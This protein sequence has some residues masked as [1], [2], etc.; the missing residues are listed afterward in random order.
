MYRFDF[1]VFN[2]C[3]DNPD[4]APEIW[5]MHKRQNSEVLFLPAECTAFGT[6]DSVMGY[7]DSTT[8]RGKGGGY[9]IHTKAAQVV[10]G[11]GN[12]SG[13]GVRDAGDGRGDSHPGGRFCREHNRGTGGDVCGTRD[14]LF[15][16][17][18]CSVSYECTEALAGRG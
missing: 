10:A 8:N 18:G 2:E 5:E 7:N 4:Y 17:G 3:A 14:I 6:F 12:G 13:A 1:F 16:C 15:A 9:E 11:S